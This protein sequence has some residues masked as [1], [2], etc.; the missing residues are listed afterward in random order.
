MQKIAE[1]KVNDNIDKIQKNT[2]A[3]FTVLVAFL[4]I[5]FSVLAVVGDSLF[6]IVL[7]DKWADAGVLA[8]FLS[9]FA[10]TTLLVQA[11]GGLFDVMSKQHTRL[12]FHIFNF[13]IRIGTLLL[14]IYLDYE[15][16]KTVFIYAVASTL[17][18]V[19]A[20]G[21]LLN[22]VQQLQSLLS[23][24]LS[25]IT[26]LILFHVV[27]AIIM[28]YFDS[29]LLI[30]VLIGVLAITWLFMIGGMNKLK[31]FRR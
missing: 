16:A 4:L 23:V 22:C 3:F 11:F 5:P 26:L 19:V 31:Q 24:L 12:I 17:M 13:I 7:G 21:L 2:D 27:A 9:Y 14:C 25:N 29:L 6:V 15:L 28:Y 30:Y 20:M 8:S 10:M 1:D 18:N